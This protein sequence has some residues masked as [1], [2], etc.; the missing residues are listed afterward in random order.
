MVSTR[1]SLARWYTHPMQEG[2]LSEQTIQAIHKSGSLNKLVI[3]M[4]GNGTQAISELMRYGNGSAT[5]LSQHLLYDNAAFANYIGGKPDKYVSAHASRQLAMAAY[6]ESLKIAGGKYPTVGIGGTSSLV[7]P[8]GERDGREHLIFVSTQD[9]LHT[10][11]ISIKLDTSLNRSR[12]QEEWI[13]AMVILQAIAA[14]RGVTVNNQL[15]PSDLVYAESNA[16]PN[17]T[18]SDVV[19]GI[20][21]FYF[22]G[23]ESLNK[24]MVICSGSFNPL[25]EAHITLL[26]LGE[27]ITG[28]R[29]I[30]ELSITNV[31]K[32]PL[33]F[34]EI[35][36]RMS[37][38]E[39]QSLPL[40]LTNQPRYFGKTKI[41]AKGSVFV[42]GSDT[43]ERVVDGRYY[44]KT[45]TPI[46]LFE[47]LGT[48][49]IVAARK[50]GDDTVLTG[51]AI[52][53][54][55]RD[56]ARWAA[57]TTC[58][59]PDDFLMDVSSTKIRSANNSEG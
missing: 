42:M 57:I 19:H 39:K 17:Q 24:S 41:F 5:L 33:D 51:E 26:K 53:K 58:I 4:A 16:Q 21:P 43:F 55:T 54:S 15:T 20:R 12:V 45:E 23:G 40:I 52:I 9:A 47:S 13:N 37:Q 56:P 44:D 8:D 22:P 28:L 29:G 11:T 50:G 59:S 30:F 3:A 10:H 1:V 35:E 38:F 34:I 25:H 18:L 27:T 49:F 6:M 32:P 2:R 36:K 46:A 31:D 14:A 7:K 48:R